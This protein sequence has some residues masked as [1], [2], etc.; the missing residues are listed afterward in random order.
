MKPNKILII[1]FSSIGD[2]VLTTPVIRCLKKQLGAEIHFLTKPQF[3]SIL[4]PNPYIDKV[5]TLQ[6]N[7]KDTLR[8]LKREGYDLVV[9]L[10]KN[11]RSQRIKLGLGLRSVSFDKINRQKWFM[12]NFKWN[13]LPQKHIV[14]RY[15]EPILPFGVNYD[16]AGLD[17]YIP[18]GEDLDVS[19]LADQYF[20]HQENLRAA[21]ANQQYV[22]L[23]IGAAHAT[24]RL[25]THK[26]TELAA[27]IIAPV[28]LLGGPDDK[29]TGEE[30]AKQA[31]QH[32]IN[33]CGAFK[34]GASASLVKQAAVVVTHDTGLMHI[35]AAFNKPIISIWGNTIPEFGMYPFYESGVDN[36]KIVQVKDLS[37]RPCS[38]IGY[39]KCP[40]GHFK[41]MEAQS[42]SEIVGQVQEKLLNA[43]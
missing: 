18:E 3:K 22:A 38:K 15:M 2:I 40:K 16:G 43:F 32:V 27:R 41:C 4:S 35:A 21:L 29:T 1:R 6:E 11:I 20:S 14:E 19:V 31:G 30:I 39:Q 28:L 24:K 7:I 23:V 37:C 17:Y 9:D 12:V 33:T 26:L 10:H 25:P 13:K 8:V 36:G 42:I 34:L 5:F